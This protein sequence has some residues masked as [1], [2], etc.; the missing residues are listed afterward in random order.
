MLSPIYNL[1]IMLFDN[2]S[3]RLTVSAELIE[4]FLAADGSLWI[5]LGTAKF[6]NEF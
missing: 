4:Y 5:K 3:H 1:I 2:L 6:K